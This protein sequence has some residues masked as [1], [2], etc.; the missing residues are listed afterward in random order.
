[1]P[2]AGVPVVFVLLL[3]VALPQEAGDE[4]RAAV[5]GRVVDAVTGQPIAGVVVTPA[6]S[7]VVLDEASPLP[8]RALTNGQ[9]AFV[10]RGLRKGTVYFTAAKNGYADATYRQRRPGGSGQGIP[11]AAGQHA[12]DVEI[13]MWRHAAITGTVVDEAGEPAVGVRVESYAQY[14]VAGRKRLNPGATG[15]T[16]DRGVYRIANL[17][18]GGYAVAVRARQNS[19]P[20]SVMD[21]FF[22]PSGGAGDEER[23]RVGRELNALGSPI[24]PK[25]SEYA[26]GA[27]GQTV[28]LP[29]GTLVPLQTPQG[30]LVYTT[31][32]YPA[33]SRLADAGLVTLRPGEERGSIDLQLRPERTF[34][35]S[36]IVAAATGP[37]PHLGVRLLAAGAEDA[38]AGI[39]A[40]TTLTDGSGAFTF[41]AVPAGQYVLTALRPPREP[42]DRSEGIS[43]TP[44][45]DVTMSSA[46]RTT[47]GPTAAMPISADTTIYARMPIS[48]GEMDVTGVVVPLA[49]APRIRGRVE[50]EGTSDKPQPAT[51]ARIRI[52]LD[53]ADGSRLPDAALAAEA[54]HPSEDGSFRTAGVPP[55]RYVL[56]INPPAG[57]FVKGAFLRGLD[58]AEVPFDLGEKDLAGVTI[59]FTD[60]PSALIGTV[61]RGTEP[62]Q[63]AIVIAFPT[64]SSAW[65]G[66]GAFPRRMRNSRPRSDGTYVMEGIVP[67]EYFV[68][69]IH[70][71][72]CPDWQDP[73]LLEALSRVARTVRLGE[74]DRRT[75]DL[76]P[77][78][79]R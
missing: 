21:V 14:F 30:L 65:R 64:D 39:D 56:R 53:P 24:V 37:V 18:P 33:A 7:A 3:A 73:A 4:R 15:V 47:A 2:A 42:F 46:V 23:F 28:T 5:S 55:G 58:L 22:S 48:V 66:R 8:P 74:G 69:A 70:E 79:I 54:G 38:V 72:E 16:D 19:I 76:T 40:A 75:E 49:A 26:F 60:R 52:N 63:D 36:G 43:V 71:D 9:G 57:W 6:G 25:G 17:M 62:D 41:A 68:A 44:G 27:A 29:P 32:F 31:V 50:F 11:L 45:G 34:R 10:L 12:R 59:T 13:R 51:V 67:G 35:V 20:D 78:V 77:V 1:M 61:R